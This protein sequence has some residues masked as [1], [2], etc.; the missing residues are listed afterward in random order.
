MLGQPV[1]L[2][3]PLAYLD[4]SG[5]EQLLHLLRSRVDQG[6]TVILVE[7]RIK[8]VQPICDRVL[9]VR[10]G[11]LWKQSPQPMPP[12]IHPAILPQ[13]LPILLLQTQQLSWNGYPP[14][15]DL[16]VYGGEAVLLKGD[17]GCDHI[18]QTP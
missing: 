12:T 14:F 7:H 6:Q 9:S 1:L 15:P 18:P 5:V 16:Q 13:P 3:E 4:A 8:V 11:Q 17:N 10:D 2:D